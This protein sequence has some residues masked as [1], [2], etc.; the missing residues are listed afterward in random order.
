LLN[1]VFSGRDASGEFKIVTRLSARKEF[2]DFCRL[3]NF[4][5]QGYSVLMNFT[6][7]GVGDI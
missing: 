1:K 2:I 5:L 3:E 7:T 4:K 6:G